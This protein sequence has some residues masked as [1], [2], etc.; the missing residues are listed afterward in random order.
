[1]TTNFLEI[2]PTKDPSNKW[3]N[4]IGAACVV[5]SI[6]AGF[7]WFTNKPINVFSK[8]EENENLQ[9]LVENTLRDDKN[10]EDN[11]AQKAI[12][13]YEEKQQTPKLPQLRGELPDEEDFS[14]KSII[15]KDKE[16]GMVMYAKNE[17]NR[18]SVASI[19]KLM[20]ALVILEKDPN[21]DAVVEVVPDDVIGTHMYAGEKYTLESLWRSA[22][23]GSSNKAVLTLADSVGWPREAFVER[24]N[25]KALELGMADTH[26]VDPTGLEKENVSTASDIAILLEEAMDINEI[27]QTVLLKEYYL[28][29]VDKKNMRHMWNTDWLLLGW[30]NNHFVDIRGG[31]TGYIPESGYNFTMQV[32]DAYGHI[33]DVVVLGAKDHEARFTEARDVAEA[34]FEDYI[35]DEEK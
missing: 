27:R 34:V 1:M 31:K 28:A 22:L 10:E 17:Y 18:R 6:I 3:R 5:L 35:W 19:T 15:V 20:S 33:L 4:F 29:S 24:M 11:F 13:D 14:A 9:E 21:W 30:V 12:P 16:T 25:G 2:D 23:I 32:A 26:F 7:L 8:T